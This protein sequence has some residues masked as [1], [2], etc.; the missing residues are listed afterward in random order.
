VQLSSP[1]VH[2]DGE[3]VRRTIECNIMHTE[4]TLK[5]SRLRVGIPRRLHFRTSLYLVEYI[6]RVLNMNVYVVWVE[7]SDAE[8]TKTLLLT[9]L[10]STYS[11]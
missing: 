4:K 10:L 8:K 6:V 11:T 2:R 3:Q 9:H 5:T 7:V 1:I